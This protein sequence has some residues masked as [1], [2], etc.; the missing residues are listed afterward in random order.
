MADERFLY[1]TPTNYVSFSNPGDA[2]E[3]L[4]ESWCRPVRGMKLVA[5]I[6]DGLQQPTEIQIRG[7]SLV[8]KTESGVDYI[9]SASVL[10]EAR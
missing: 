2:R 10:K 4:P 8:I 1:Q 9:V 7:G 5:T 6:P 3:W